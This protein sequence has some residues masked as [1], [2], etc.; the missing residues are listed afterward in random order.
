MEDGG[1]RTGLEGFRGTRLSRS[2][3]DGDTVCPYFVQVEPVHERVPRL[4][5]GGSSVSPSGQGR[6]HGQA[7]LNMPVHLRQ[8]H[9]RHLVGDSLQRVVGKGLL[10]DAELAER[11]RGRRFR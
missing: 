5:A 10:G 11:L 3:A 2:L 7:D 8:D 1:R 4:F 9:V 6:R